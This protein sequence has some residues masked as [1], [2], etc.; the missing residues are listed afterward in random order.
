MTFVVRNSL[1]FVLV[2]DR[3]LIVQFAA[4]NGSDLADAAEIVAPYVHFILFFFWHV[5]F[6][7]ELMFQR[8]VIA[9]FVIFFFS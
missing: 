6:E 8:K 1:C 3:P 2:G 9:L 4:N 5:L 7:L